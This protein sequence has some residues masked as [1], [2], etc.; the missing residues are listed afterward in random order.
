M[1]TAA[2]ITAQDK[3]TDPVKLNRGNANISVQGTFVATLW[4]QRSFNN[5]HTWGDVESYTAPTELVFTEPEEGAM[6]Y[7]LGVKTGEY[8]SVQSLYFC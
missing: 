7:R 2:T 8:T 5:G 6:I 3:W 1:Y 4:L